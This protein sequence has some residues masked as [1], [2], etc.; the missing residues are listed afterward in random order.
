M[1]RCGMSLG[2]LCLNAEGVDADHVD[3]LLN[4]AADPEPRNVVE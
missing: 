3:P 2:S 4:T 1:G